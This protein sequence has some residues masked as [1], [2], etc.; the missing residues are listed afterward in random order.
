MQISTFPKSEMFDTFFIDYHTGA[1]D[2]TIQ[3]PQSCLH[4]YFT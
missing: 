2:N 1:Y 4:V 3:V